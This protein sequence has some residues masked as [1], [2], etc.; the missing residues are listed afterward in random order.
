MP[1]KKSIISPQ[2]RG[3]FVHK[4]LVSVGCLSS[5][6]FVADFIFPQPTYQCSVTRRG[7]K[8]CRGGLVEDQCPN[9]R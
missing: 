7:K 2:K 1:E 4:Y 9:E 3:T 8:N 6:F 5:F